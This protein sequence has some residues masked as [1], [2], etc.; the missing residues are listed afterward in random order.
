MKAVVSHPAIGA[1]VIVTLLALAFPGSALGQAPPERNA[2]RADFWVTEAG[3]SHSVAGPCSDH[4]PSFEVGKLVNVG[5]PLAAGATLFVG[6]NGD[7]VFGPLPR[8]RVWAS[9]EVAMDV[10]GGVLFGASRVRPTGYV[11]LNYRDLLAGFVQYE[12]YRDGGCGQPTEDQLFFGVKV[13]SRPG[14]WTAAVGSVIAGIIIVV[15]I[16][17][18]EN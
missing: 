14:I 12:R 11:S 4:Y 8:V 17:G 6:H 1:P 5:G 2:A 10:A 3:Y 7:V 18:I 9:S 13:G 16:S 15:L